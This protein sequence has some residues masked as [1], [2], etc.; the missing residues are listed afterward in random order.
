MSLAEL[1]KVAPPPKEPKDVPADFDA[2]WQAAEERLKLKF[3]A[4]YKE[5]IQTYGSGAFSYERYRIYIF[6]P[7]AP[8]YQKRCEEVL[9]GVRFAHESGDSKY[10]VYPDEG[11]LFPWGLD[12]NGCAVFWLTTVKSDWLTVVVLPEGGDDITQSFKLT[13]TSFLAKALDNKVKVKAWPEGF[14][15]DIDREYHPCKVGQ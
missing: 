7:L 5:F 13:M 14:T 8:S 15:T 2:A 11:G 10:H 3:P 1:V 12:S 9:D 4:D 6:N